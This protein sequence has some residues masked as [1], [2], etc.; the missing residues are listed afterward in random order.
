MEKKTVRGLHLR[1]LEDKKKIRAGPAIKK[2][3]SQKKKKLGGGFI[4]PT[5]ATYQEKE[6]A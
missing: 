1:A 2:E 5:G 4:R 6:T 3:N